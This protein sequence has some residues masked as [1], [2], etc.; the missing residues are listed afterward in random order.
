MGVSEKVVVITGAT[1]GI[2]KNM[3]IY[4]CIGKLVNLRNSRRKTIQLTP[5][6]RGASEIVVGEA[7]K[8][9]SR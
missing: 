6:T 2:G 5:I 8:D 1:R 9:F 4:L 3:A 7:L